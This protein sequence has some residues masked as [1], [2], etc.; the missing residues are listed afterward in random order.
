LQGLTCFNFSVSLVFSE[1]CLR[2]A[3]HP[4]PT[5]IGCLIFKEQMG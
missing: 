3:P 5:P 1:Q 4:A 2:T